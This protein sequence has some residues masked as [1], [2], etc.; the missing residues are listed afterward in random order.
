VQGSAG[1]YR[2]GE[3]Y[4]HAVD[5]RLAV[6]SGYPSI[7]HYFRHHVRVLSQGNL[8]RYGAVARAFH[9]SVSEK[10]GMVRLEALLTYGRLAGMTWFPDEPGPLPIEVPVAGGPV[11]TKP[12]AECSMEELTRA[13]RHKRYLHRQP[14]QETEAEQLRRYQQTLARYFSEN[15]Q[16]PVHIDLG[17]QGRTARLR[18]RRIRLADLPRLIEALRTCLRSLR[19]VA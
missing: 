3:L 19:V 13:L 17:L 1:H 11:V 7:R 18:V 10:Y 4:N 12:F 2:I 9:Q 16:Q 5:R 8:T 6:R 14:S 15:T